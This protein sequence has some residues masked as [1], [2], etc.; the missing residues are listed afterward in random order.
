[1]TTSVK[2]GAVAAFWLAV[3]LIQIFNWDHGVG[4]ALVMLLL[5]AAAPFVIAAARQTPTPLPP[6]LQRA[7]AMTA[8]ALLALEIVYLGT[9]IIHPHLIDVPMTTLA[10]ADAMLHGANPYVLPLDTGPEAVGFTG[11]KYLP[12]MILAYLPLG[13]PLGQRGVLLTNLVLLLASL[14][15]MKQLARSNLA[16]LLFLMLPITVQQIFAKGATDLVTVVPVL[17]AFA[18]AE[19]SSFLAGICLGLSMAAKPV[20]GG[21]FLPCLIPPTKR[22]HYAAGVAV[23]LLPILPFLLASPQSLI[24]NTVWFNLSRIPDATSWLYEASP[25]VINAAHL[26]L[27]AFFLGVGA[28]VWRQAPPLATRCLLG[29]MLTI[30]AILCGPGAHH[31]Y[32]LWWLP[33]YGVG[34]ALALAPVDACQ[35]RA[36]RYTSAA[37][38]DIRGS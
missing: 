16:P 28:Y 21:L 33:F 11:Y 29:A 23:G 30:A 13:V 15:L 6:R 25:S 3:G 27:I 18:V 1:M 31:N 24:A 37:G 22:W 17:M 12:V 34:L 4:K 5:L 14:W 19:R 10:A 26:A 20:P 32:Q 35:E 7:I 38:L 36:V 9:R 2:I 8:G